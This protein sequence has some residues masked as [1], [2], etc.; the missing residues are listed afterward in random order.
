MCISL[1]FDA[2]EL[3]HRPETKKDNYYNPS[4]NLKTS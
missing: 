3:Q 1:I 4:Q 2:N